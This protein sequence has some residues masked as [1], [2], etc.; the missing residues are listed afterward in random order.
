ML[1]CF[2]WTSFLTRCVRWLSQ[3]SKWRVA[4]T[5]FI[6]PATISAWVR[7]VKLGMGQPR[8]LRKPLTTELAENTRGESA[9]RTGRLR[10]RRAGRAGLAPGDC[11]Q[12][13]TY[14]WISA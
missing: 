8:S 5:T 12:M 1:A 2:R 7:E 10:G 6:A 9:E 14:C 3:S 4:L 11:H 13:W